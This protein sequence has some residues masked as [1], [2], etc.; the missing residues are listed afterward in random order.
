MGEEWVRLPPVTPAQI[1]QA[2]LI[3]RYFTGNLNTSISEIFEGTEINYL[4]A[5]I[6]RISASTIISPRGYYEVGNLNGEE[7]EGNYNFGIKI[8]IL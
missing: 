7:E 1:Q 5:Q 8:I 3:K 4:R 6:A 2:R